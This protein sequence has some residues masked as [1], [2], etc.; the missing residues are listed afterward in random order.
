MIIFLYGSDGYRL[1]QNLEK[2]VAEY[3][4]KHENGMAFYALDFSEN[5]G[6]EIENLD[7]ILK[8]ISFFDEKKL[9]VLKNTFGAGEKIAGL[10]KKWDLAGDKDKIIVFAEN[11][12]ETELAKRSKKFFTLLSGGGNMVRSFELLSGKKLEDWVVREAETIGA[13]IEPAAARKLVDFAN[14][15]SWRLAIELEKLASYAAAGGNNRISEKDIELLVTP[16]INLNIFE[17]IDAIGQRS[18]GKAALLLNKHLLEG[19]DPYY[20]FSM[21]IYQFRNLLRVKSLANTNGT[22][23]PTSDTIA[24]KTGLHPFVARKALEQSR[25]F[26]LEELKQKFTR[27]AD[28]DTAIKNGE[29]DIVDCLYQI[30]LS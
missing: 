1:K 4:K 23:T 15:D 13:K 27:L 24:K 19:E 10:I 11:G 14:N 20:L 21:I 22:S 5:P 12:K 7:N 29:I 25:K 6:G 3:K 26:E 9:I 17:T 18:R 28:Y 30:A 8:T 16:K 2:I